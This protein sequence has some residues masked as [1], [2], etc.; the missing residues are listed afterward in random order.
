AA[1]AARRRRAQGV[2]RDV[3]GQEAVVAVDGHRRHRRG[4][5][6][7]R[8][9]LRAAPATVADGG[10]RLRL[11]GALIRAA[12][13]AGLAALVAVG[14]GAAPEDV[15]S[16]EMALQPSSGLSPSDVGAVEILVFDGASGGCARVLTGASPLDDAGLVLVAHALFTVDG[17]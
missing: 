12:V 17:A 3:E 14:C 6:R 11:P 2:A 1:R 7:R 10:R 16:V 13:V 8:A 5:R 9:L 4:R 15:A